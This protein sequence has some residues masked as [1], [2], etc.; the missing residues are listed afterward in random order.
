[1]NTLDA[2]L[3]IGELTLLLYLLWRMCDWTL[4]AIGEWHAAVKE[5]REE[6]SPNEERES[7]GR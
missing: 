4:D 2:L 7:S 1:M 6:T 5:G 3:L